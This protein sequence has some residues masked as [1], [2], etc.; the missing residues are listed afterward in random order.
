MLHQLDVEAFKGLRDVSLRKLANMNIVTGRNDVGKTTLLEAIFLLA[1]GPRAALNAL[2]VLMPQRDEAVL[3]FGP[4][5]IIDDPWATLFP[6]Q[7]DAPRKVKV[8]GSYSGRS[9]SVEFSPAVSGSDQTLVFEPG[10]PAQSEPAS[11]SIEVRSRIDSNPTSKHRLIVSATPQSTSP[12]GQQSVTVQTRLEPEDNTAPFLNA[13]YMKARAIPSDLLDVF[14]EMRRSG[15][16]D[17]L[18]EALRLIDPEID[19]LEI[20][21]N[22]GQSILHARL[23]DGRRLPIRQM[24]DG[25]V[26]ALRCIL[27]IHQSKGGIVLVDEM[28]N[29]I[30]WAALKDYWTAVSRMARKTRTQVFATTHSRELI[31]AAAASESAQSGSLALYQLDRRSDGSIRAT[32]YSLEQILAGLDLQLELR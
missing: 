29:G 28:D 7:G 13:H 18:I 14:S 21:V 6:L 32:D 8:R 22:H 31:E 11:I 5:R 30:H 20:L 1:S 17:A 24:G 26:S 27:A 12:G 9:Y 10:R 25:T 16:A 3:G 15:E 4:D 23:T 2:M 19:D